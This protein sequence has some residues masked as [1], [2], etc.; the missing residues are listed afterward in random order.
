VVVLIGFGLALFTSAGSF[1]CLQG[2][3]LLQN[4]Y[5]LIYPGIPTCQSKLDAIWKNAPIQAIPGMEILR[6]PITVMH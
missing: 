3:D 2:I 1:I 4:K 6:T 5:L